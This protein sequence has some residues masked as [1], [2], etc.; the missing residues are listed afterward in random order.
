MA[1][2]TESG[3][4]RKTLVEIIESLQ[5]RFAKKLGDDWNTTED[6]VENQFISVFAEE[7]DQVWQGMSGV[8]KSQTIDAEDIYLDDVLSQQG[9]FRKGKAK[10]GGEVVVFA[11]KATAV[12][13]YTITTGR[14]LQGSNSKSYVTTTE[15]D[16][17]NYMSCYKLST[18]DLVSGTTYQFLMY[19]TQNPN[20]NT[21]TWTVGTTLEEKQDMLIALSQFANN[22]ISLLPSSAYFDVETN[23]LYI[24]FENQLNLPDPMPK[25][26]LYLSSTPKVGKA[27]YRISAEA[28]EAGFFPLPLNSI[29]NMSPS[30]TGFDSV[31]NWT[32]FSSGS[33]VQ[34]DSDYRLTY[35]NNEDGSLAGTPAKIKKDLL[36]V[37]G[38]LAVEI[39]QNPTKDFIYDL[40]NNLVAEPFTYNT[41]VLG[42]SDL[43]V[44]KAIGSNAP[45][46][47]AQYGTTSVSY[48]DDTGTP[49]N[50]EFSRAQYLSYGV[51]VTYKTKDGTSLTDIERQAVNTLM[52]ELTSELSIGATIPLEQIQA[53]VYRA[54]PFQRVTTASVELKDFSVVGSQYVKEDIIPPY[55]KKPQLLNSSIVYQ[56][57]N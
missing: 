41:V 28:V 45:V 10:G 9:W 35:L 2:I 50:V 33:E 12:D 5:K 51:R 22:N 8:Y 40:D 13:G 21:F 48:S 30:F 17:D 42:G 34:T 46:N 56:K 1:G 37:D 18:N 32:A 24:S 53:S 27:G 52:I 44:A 43:D 26:E 47:T 14:V 29:L 38:V 3:F 16:A 54:L 31:V 15:K 49:V 25:G 19:N 6:S 20:T 57:G 7:L 11:N 23:T 4:Q 39:Y 36:D 55:N